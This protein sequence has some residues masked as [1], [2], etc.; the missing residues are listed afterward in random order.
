M[1]D[2]QISRAQKNTRNKIYRFRKKGLDEERLAEIDPRR[3]T[4][5]MTTAEKRAYLAELKKFNGRFT[6]YTVGADSNGDVGAVPTQMVMEYRK[7]EREAN[8]LKKK[9]ASAA[10]RAYGSMPVM[11]NGNEMTRAEYDK[12]FG[13]WV[14][15]S[16]LAYDRGYLKV[17]RRQYGFSSEQQLMRAIDA[18]R[19]A[20]EKVKRIDTNLLN[21]K[22]SIV[23]RMREEN[24]PID[25][26]VGVENLTLNQLQY[27][28]YNSDFASQV[29][30]YHYE[31]Y[32]AEGHLRRSDAAFER[33]FDNVRDLLESAQRNV[34]STPFRPLLAGR[35]KRTGH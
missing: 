20:I 35:K 11:K 1:L 13:E 2:L 22:E 31:S 15:Y 21:Y 23:N 6:G 4:K 26:V 32:Y 19:N 34:P 5:D 28:Y 12:R 27:L 33:S 7:I 14:K 24:A 17:A 8:K 9:L 16:D 10:Q 25:I 29:S 30:Q 3:S 18:Q